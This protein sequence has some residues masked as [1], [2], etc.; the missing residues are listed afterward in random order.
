MFKISLG[1]RESLACDGISRRH[2]LRMGACGLIGGLTLPRILELQAK[3]PLAKTPQAKSCIFLFLSGGPPHQD[4]WD[5]KPE[6]PLEIRGPFKQI[7]T[8]IPGINVTDQ[9]PLCAKL[10]DKYTIV[11]SHSHR[12]N[13]H[14]TGYH[15]VLTGRKPN[16]S[17]GD[18]PVPNNDFYPSIG[19]VVSRERGPRGALPAYIN[20]PHPMAGGGPG[21]YGAEHAPF[22]IE[23]DPTQPDFEV[24]D[25]RPDRNLS[26]K[27]LSLREK[28]LTGIDQLERTRNN[29]QAKVMSTYY[30]KAYNLIASTDAK[31][32]FDIHSESDSTRDAYGRTQIGQC[33][34]LARRLVE[35]GCRFVGVDAPGW[36]VHFN[37][38]PS[39]Q[40]DLI[41]YAD[42]A[43]STLVSDLDQRG[44]LDETLVIMMGEMGRTP[45]INAKA[46]R[47][48]WSMAQTIIFA[49]GGIKPGQVIGATD[50]QA[51]APIT[52]PIGVNDLLFTISKLM[53]IDP[54]KT[55]LGPLGRP[56]P[57]VDGG[58]MIRG[59]V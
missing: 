23:A 37:C 16:F 15:Y 11:R 8:K 12:D 53:G 31:K 45:R 33:A 14:S 35:G 27:R 4:M 34:L 58:K 38:F 50:K 30:E 43:F 18:N 1:N 54:E 22:V 41:P 26:Q 57:I 5:P 21:F 24:K 9:L 48:H 7:Q 59:L 32:A 51:A 17:D 19:S 39:L 3:A 56:V 6:A 55:Y 49:G 10:V 47:D 44:L 13:G 36:D 52:E 25:L 2:S 20:L 28:L 29:G 42:R 40:T 46:G